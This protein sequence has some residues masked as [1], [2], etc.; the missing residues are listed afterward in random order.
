MYRPRKNNRCNATGKK[1]SAIHADSGASRRSVRR[2]ASGTETRHRPCT[3]CSAVRG[4]TIHI[5][6]ARSRSL[7]AFGGRIG[8]TLY[9]RL[10]IGHAGS[11][12]RSRK[13]AMLTWAGP[14]LVRKGPETT[15]TSASRA[16]NVQKATPAILAS[17]MHCFDGDGFITKRPMPPPIGQNSVATPP[18]SLTVS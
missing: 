9:R 10:S 11:P 18:I 7:R 13:W 6:P 5:R 1:N 2:A 4:G 12:A 17:Q 16:S 8:L 14:S 3:I 15:T